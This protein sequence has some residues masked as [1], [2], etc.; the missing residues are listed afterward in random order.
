M[1]A[2]SKIR[3]GIVFFAFAT[4]Y[5]LIVSTLFW[6]QVV[7]GN[8]FKKLANR[9]YDVVVKLSPLRALIFDRAGIPVATNADSLSAFILPRQLQNKDKVTRFLQHNFPQAYHYWQEHPNRHFLYIKRR[10]T[11]EQT[12]LIEQAKI[13][14]IKF[15]KEPWRYYPC[16]ALATIVGITNIENR[17]LFGIEG[18]HDQQLGGTPTICTLKRDASGNFFFEKYTHVAGHDGTPINLNLDS[19]LQFL[20][21][22]ELKETLNTWQAKEGGVLIM[23][24][25]NGDIIVMANAPD[26]DPNKVEKLEIANTKNRLVCDSYEAG[27]VIK[28]FCAL[29]ALEEGVVTPDEF[30]DCKGAKTAFVNGFKINTV[31][32]HGVISFSEVIEKSN[33]IGIATVAMRLGTKLYHHYI[34]CG[35]GSKTGIDFSG[36]DPGYVSHPRNWCKR[37][38]ISL[39]YGYEIRTSMIQLARAFA[40]FSNGGKLVRPRILRNTPA[41]SSQPLYSQL[42]IEKIRSMLT[43]TVDK[44]TATKGR[45]N[46]YLVMGKTGTAKLIENGHY[47]DNKNLFSFCGIIEKGDYKRVIVTYIK[48]IKKQGH[49]QASTVAV[50]FFES[51]AQKMLIH[52]KVI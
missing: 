45:I 43:K 47:S 21:I 37:S 29:A 35:F 9:Q 3:L 7:R 24:P 32:G 31:H 16:P 46:G 28:T 20:A 5:A 1:T 49:I 42:T 38:I 10:L 11:P 25:V 14:D 33:N 4:F 30:I 26:F 2:S 36:E 48:E 41:Y 17:G 23:D 50:P 15:I 19:R 13:D 51:I 12:A 6:L 39:S 44:G 22:R 18:F 27:S 52:E 8:F 40:L 34:R